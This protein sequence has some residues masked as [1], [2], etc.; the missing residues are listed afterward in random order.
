MNDTPSLEW[1]FLIVILSLGGV[2]LL[3]AELVV[4]WLNAPKKKKP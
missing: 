1:V 3:F 4:R 2:A